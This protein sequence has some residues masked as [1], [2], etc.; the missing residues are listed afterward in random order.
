MGMSNDDHPGH[1]GWLI[2]F[3]R[4]DGRWRELTSAD[5]D[6]GRSVPV[7]AVA[8][9]CSCGWRSPRAYSPI[10]AVWVPHTV[11]VSIP[12][13]AN[14]HDDFCDA[15]AWPLWRAHLRDVAPM[16]GREPRS[17]YR[18]P[19]EW[20]ALAERMGIGPGCLAASRKVGGA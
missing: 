16:A 12:G 17:P 20:H 14:A 19:Y 15:F 7:L 11:L 10:G 5:S 8:V 3:V 6:H 13:I 18:G 4:E 1:E 2:G 9:E